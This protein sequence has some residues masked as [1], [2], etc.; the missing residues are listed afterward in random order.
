MEDL[1]T[2]TALHAMAERAISPLTKGKKH[3]RALILI[4]EEVHKRQV[5]SNVEGLFLE[6]C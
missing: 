4:T 1:A 2:E 6:R 3:S 5:L